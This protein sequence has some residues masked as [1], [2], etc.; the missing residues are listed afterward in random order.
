MNYDEAIGSSLSSTYEIRHVNGRTW[1]CRVIIGP[2]HHGLIKAGMGV[3]VGAMLLGNRLPT[4]LKKLR[5][6]TDETTDEIFPE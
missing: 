2:S 1:W 4:A 3:I 6:I 5:S